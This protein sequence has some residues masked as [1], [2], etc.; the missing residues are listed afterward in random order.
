MDLAGDF[1]LGKTWLV[2]KCYPALSHK[3]ISECEEYGNLSGD[4]FVVGFVLFFMRFYAVFFVVAERG[5]NKWSR[6]FFP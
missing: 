1:F 3:K 6:L 4:H 2:V 5:E